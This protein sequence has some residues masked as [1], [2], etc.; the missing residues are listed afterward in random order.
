MTDNTKLDLIIGQLNELKVLPARLDTVISGLDSFRAE[1]SVWKQ[2]V[3][4]SL[5]EVEHSVEFAHSEILDLKKGVDA[6][7][8]AEASLPTYEQF[9]TVG[10][11]VHNE[12][13]KTRI[14]SYK[15]NLIF[16]GIEGQERNRWVTESKLRE[17]WVSC[18]EISEETTNSIFIADCHRLQPRK[19]GRPA[20][21]VFV[22]S[23]KC[24]TGILS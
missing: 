15:H 3:D 1:V 17:F 23:C 9:E 5:K 16:E 12:I 11:D 20:N 4:E 19:G 13:L 7:K 18:M 6:L 2:S 22:N 21:I 10:Q 8:K 24:L 14:Q